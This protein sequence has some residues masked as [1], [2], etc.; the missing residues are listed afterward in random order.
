[1]RAGQQRTRSIVRLQGRE[2]PAA[3]SSTQPPAQQQQQQSIADTPWCASHEMPRSR[4]DADNDQRTLVSFQDLKLTQ[5]VR[6][7][8]TVHN[9]LQCKITV[10]TFRVSRR[11]REMYIDHAGL[12][13]CVCVHVYLSAAACPHYCMDLAVTWR[14]GRGCPL[15]VHYW[16]DLQSVHGNWLL[17]QR[18]RTRNVSDC[19][20]SR[21][22]WFV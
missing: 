17:W 13:V 5:H 14:N 10:I 18:T 12:C 3:S 2:A 21:N 19:L 1:M 20:Y 6:N 9:T 8:Y 16:A 22:A 15:I 4:R 11:R 7:N